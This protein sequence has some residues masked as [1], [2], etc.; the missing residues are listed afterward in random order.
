MNYVS[1]KTGVA[2]ADKDAPLSNLCFKV[3]DKV[4][5]KVETTT[6]FPLDLKC[7]LLITREDVL[8][9]E[10]IEQLTLETKLTQASLKQA[11]GEVQV[12]DDQEA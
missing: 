1:R 5:L 9:Y 7:S 10:Q 6:D 2:P 11:R 3:Y 4:K 8:E 12:V